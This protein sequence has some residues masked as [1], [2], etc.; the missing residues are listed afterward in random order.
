MKLVDGEGDDI[1]DNFLEE[2][3]LISSCENE[4]G[5]NGIAGTEG[6]RVRV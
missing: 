6:W 3:L 2:V 4:Q 5:L 1:K